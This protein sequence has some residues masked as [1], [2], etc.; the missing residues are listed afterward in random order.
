MAKT[1]MPVQKLAP[2]QAKP[3]TAGDL[4]SSCFQPL[5]QRARRGRRSNTPTSTSAAHAHVSDTRQLMHA[6]MST[7]AAAKTR[8]LSEDCCGQR[9]LISPGTNAH[10]PNWTRELDEE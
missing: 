1:L 9:K 10:F 2:A 7:A 6:P 8:E 5:R 3:T 4:G